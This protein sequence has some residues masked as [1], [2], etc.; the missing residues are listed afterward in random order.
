V[1]R[2]QKKLAKKLAESS[3]RRRFNL[4]EMISRM[5]KNY[6]TEDFPKSKPVGKEVW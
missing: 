6:K 3:N 4:V 2:H 5:P 1:K